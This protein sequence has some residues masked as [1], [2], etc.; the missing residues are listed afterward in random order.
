MLSVGQ[1][2][3]TTDIVAME[4]KPGHLVKLVSQTSVEKLELALRSRN[5]TGVCGHL[6]SLVVSNN[7]VDNTPIALISNHLKSALFTMHAEGASQDTP[8]KYII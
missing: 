5:V 1:K 7:G 4:S 6:V 2:I 8:G 3:V